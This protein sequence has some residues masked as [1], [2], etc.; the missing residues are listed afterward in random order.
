MQ[1]S[2][3]SGKMRSNNFLRL[4]YNS[5]RG[6]LPLGDI[7]SSLSL[8]KGGSRE[9]WAKAI[10]VVYGELRRLAASHLRRESENHTL[11]PTELVHEAYL[12]L[13]RQHHMDWQ[14]R[15]HFFGVAAHLMRLILVD[16]ARRRNRAKRGGGEAGHVEFSVVDPQGKTLDLDALDQAL[17]RLAQLDPRQCRIVE[18]RYFGGLTVDE[19]AQA[20][21]ISPRTV[22]RDWEV[23]RAWLHGE[24]RKE[25]H[26][27]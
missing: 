1:T 11:Q 18:M 3:K 23:A 7:T 2:V 13:I 8:L 10:P 4:G 12:R 22:R 25:A 16:H 20:L 17:E 27:P 15:T 9:G 6:F 21:G 26:E 5:E 24:L 14:S 19:T